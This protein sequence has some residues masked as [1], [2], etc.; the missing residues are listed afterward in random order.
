MKITFLTIG[1]FKSTECEALARGYLKLAGRFAEVEAVELR[2]PKGRAGH[3][4]PGSND[5]ALDAWLA[6]RGS[7]VFLTILDEKGRQFA[8]R[9]FAARVKKVRD[10]SHSEWIV[11][12]GGAHGYGP[13]LQARAQL[14][15]SLSPLTLA[16]DLAAAVA[17]EQI[18]RALAILHKHPY[19]ND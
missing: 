5:E 13:A 12:V 15:W 18:F 14:L 6:K 9:D 10:G 2:L 1:K 19:H 3:E 8:S 16:H 4:A 11:A 7:R 17:A